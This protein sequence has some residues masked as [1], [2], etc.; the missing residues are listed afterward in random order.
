MCSLLTG[1]DWVGETHTHTQRERE[2]ERWGEGGKDPVAHQPHSSRHWKYHR[3]SISR[4]WH[5]FARSTRSRSIRT[6]PDSCC[7]RLLT[8]QQL[9]R[10]L[11]DRGS[12]PTEDC[13]VHSCCRTPSKMSEVS[14]R[15][16]VERVKHGS[17]C[18]VSLVQTTGVRV[19]LAVTRC[20][21]SSHHVKQT[22]QNAPARNKPHRITRASTC[23]QRTA[24]CLRRLQDDPQPRCGQESKLNVLLRRSPLLLWLGSQAWLLQW[25]ASSGCGTSAHRQWA[26][27]TSAEA[28]GLLQSRVGG[29]PDGGLWKCPPSLMQIFY[30]GYFMILSSCTDV[31][32]SHCAMLQHWRELMKNYIVEIKMI[33]LFFFLLWQNKSWLT[34]PA[35]YEVLSFLQHHCMDP[36]QTGCI[37][38]TS[39][40]LCSIFLMMYLGLDAAG[41]Y[42]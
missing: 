19:W 2:R 33:D 23:R 1:W 5:H 30:E 11:P 15:A 8:P 21:R 13:E 36:P 40:L 41:K 18:G 35:V 14:G 25:E 27:W 38:F 24:L 17:R 31:C 12:T 39:V 22:C 20:S 34:G 16:C 37:C 28:W 6:Q 32:A 9:S 4:L 10:S 26:V 3:R 42:D 7:L 29:P